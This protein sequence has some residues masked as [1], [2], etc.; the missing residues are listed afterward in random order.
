MAKSIIAKLTLATVGVAAIAISADIRPASASNLISDNFVRVGIGETVVAPFT[1]PSTSTVN[2]YSGLLEVIVSGTGFSAGSSINDA[3]YGVPSGVPYDPQY[4]QL[5][6][7]WQGQPLFPLVGESRNINNFIS[8]I[9][10]V[11]TVPFGTTPAYN[12]NSIYKFVVNL[13]ATA[14]I[15]SFGVSDGLFGD[16]GGRY[17]IEINQLRRITAR[18]I[19]EPSALGALALLGISAVVSKK[20]LT[21]STHQS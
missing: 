11:G 20:K 1:S 10:G 21:A 7:G 6:I 8:F 2:S 4:Y 12:P 5:N 13:P 18:D 9:D 15:L 17:N 14:G 3:F 19:P 16:N